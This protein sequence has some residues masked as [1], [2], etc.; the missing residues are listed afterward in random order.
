MGTD[1][2]RARPDQS[3]KHTLCYIV[4]YRFHQPLTLTL[5]PMS[6][7]QGFAG[8]K[9]VDRYKQYGE[10]YIAYTYL[11]LRSATVGVGY[12]FSTSYTLLIID[13]LS[14]VRCE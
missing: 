6:M 12:C 2:A 8:Q 14:A 13:S 9:E 10:G 1:L 4:N 11:V 5:T 7:S 3:N